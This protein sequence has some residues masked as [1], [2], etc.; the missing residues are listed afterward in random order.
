MEWDGGDFFFFDRECLNGVD[1]NEV[2]NV[3]LMTQMI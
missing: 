3:L 2:V 1:G